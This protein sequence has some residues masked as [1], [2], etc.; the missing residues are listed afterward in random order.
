[1]KFKTRLSLT[2]SSG[3]EPKLNVGSGFTVIVCESDRKHPFNS[4]V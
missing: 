2:Q 1:M 4:P 3:I